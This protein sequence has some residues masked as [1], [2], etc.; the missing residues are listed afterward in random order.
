[1]LDATLAQCWRQ[2]KGRQSGPAHFAIIGYGKLGG[3]ELG[4]ASDLDI[5]FLYEVA[6]SDAHAEAIVERHT[7]AS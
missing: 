7:P 3:K 1:M 6:E 2:L 5:V 4:Y